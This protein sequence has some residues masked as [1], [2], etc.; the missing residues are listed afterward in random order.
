ME[1]CALHNALQTHARR[2]LYQSFLPFL[3]GVFWRSSHDT[4]A[5][6]F[7][8]PVPCGRTLAFSQFLAIANQAAR[9]VVL[10]VQK[11]CFSLPQSLPEVERVPRGQ[12]TITR[13]S[14]WGQ[15]GL[16]EREGARPRPGLGQNP[17]HRTRAARRP[18]W[19]PVSGPWRPGGMSGQG[20]P[21]G[22]A[23]RP[24]PGKEGAT[25]PAPP[26]VGRG[27]QGPGFRSTELG[28]ETPPRR[29]EKRLRLDFTF[30]SQEAPPLGKSG[31]G[32]ARAQ[33]GRFGDSRP[34]P[35]PSAGQEALP[36]GKGPETPTSPG[37]WPGPSRKQ[38]GTK[39]HGSPAFQN[40]PGAVLCRPGPH[41]CH[42]V[43]EVRSGA[44]A[45]GGQTSSNDCHPHWAVFMLTLL[46]YCKLM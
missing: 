6:P 40:G 46:E 7:V 33:Q 31:R 22:S 8:Y 30:V 35:R 14:E 16:R 45:D 44:G 28:Q 10:Q 13:L 12:C 41:R 38:R 24:S 9:R 1:S 17:A 3:F 18:R 2:S 21:P 15:G 26:R 27:L 19:L 43:S 5:S 32:G 11:G 25:R 39:T 42:H 37:L 23:A 34:E 36:S 29:A 4:G 20:D